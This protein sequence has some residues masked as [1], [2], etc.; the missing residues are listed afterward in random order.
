M[1]IRMRSWM[2]AAALGVGVAGSIVPRTVHAEPPPP[3]ADEK[4]KEAYLKA[5]ALLKEAAALEKQA[6][7]KREAA[8]KAY[9]QAKRDANKLDDDADAKKAEAR[10]LLKAAGHYAKDE[11]RAEA[12][13]AKG[14][15]IL[16]TANAALAKAEQLDADAAAERARAKSQRDAAAVLLANNPDE[17]MK[18]DAAELIKG[19]EQDEKDA[20]ELEKQ[21]KDQRDKSAKLRAQAIAI[22]TEANKL[23]P[24]GTYDY[25]VPV[26]TFPKKR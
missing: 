5:R 19:A 13:R 7:D 12:L 18:K 4:A 6:D 26:P 23:D 17:Q 8:K 11:L 20:A 24:D 22:F 15:S 3:G 10:K 1:G 9:N 14:R 25:G 16:Q 2:M 21:E